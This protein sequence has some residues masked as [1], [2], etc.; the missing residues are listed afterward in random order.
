MRIAFITP[1]LIKPSEPGLSAAAAAQWFRSRGVDAF[2]VDASIGW[3]TRA[4]SERNLADILEQ[5]GATQAQRQ[6][7]RHIQ[8][9]ALQASETYRDR[10][11]YSSACSH[12]VNALKLAARPT[13]GFLLRVADVEWQGHRPQRSEDLEAAATTPGPFDAYFREE[14]IPQ[15]EQA[16][17]THVALSLTFLHQTYAAFRL[18]QPPPPMPAGLE[19]CFVWEAEP[20]TGRTHQIRVHAAAHGFPILG[21]TLYGGTPAA[22]VYLH[23]AQLGFRHPATGENVLFDAPP[24]FSADPRAALRA[25]V[26]DPA[27]TDAFRLVHGAADAR[28][29][30]NLW[31][32]AQGQQTGAV[33]QFTRRAVGL[34]GIPDNYSRIADDAPDGFRKFLD[35]HVAAVADVDELFVA[36]IVHQEHAR[37]R[38]IVAEEKF[39]QRLA[40]SPAGD[41]GG[42]G[43]FGVVEA[44]DEG[45]QDV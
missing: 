35:R 10:R 32:P 28:L 9:K 17:T 26:I 19:R 18:A 29:Q 45:G 6:A 11:V 21:D 39:P 33:H 36:V 30:I 38:Q 25:A 3:Y 8:E 12:L 37:P 24:D 31:P 4:L 2:S 15:L 23:A 44:V 13:P 20:A 40:G 5:G 42:A 41:G 43:D 7:A 1:P 14:L 16:G 34:G 22:R 27:A